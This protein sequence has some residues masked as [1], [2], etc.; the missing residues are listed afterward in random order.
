MQLTKL[1][2]LALTT[3]IIGCGGQL[4]GVSVICYAEHDECPSDEAAT[5]YAEA[6][7]VDLRDRGL[8]AEWYDSNYVFYVE[9]DPDGSEHDVIGYTKSPSRVLVTGCPVFL[10]EI[11]HVDLWRLYS[12][13]DGDH[14]LGKGYWTEA[15]NVL[16]ATTGKEVCPEFAD[17]FAQ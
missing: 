9:I 6:L 11:N 4:P 13:P 14:E 15:D 3:T 8:M 1:I 16:I 17:P 5:G 2:L 12:N 7:G 10:H